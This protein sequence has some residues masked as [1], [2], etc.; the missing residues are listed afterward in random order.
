MVGITESDHI[1][2]VCQRLCF[3]VILLMC[4]DG[5]MHRLSGPV[6]LAVGIK[7]E[8]IT[9]FI[10]RIIIK[11]ATVSRLSRQVTILPCR[12]EQFRRIVSVTVHPIDSFSLFVTSQRH[13]LVILLVSLIERQLQLG[14]W[15][16]LS[17]SGIHCHITDF[18]L[19]QA[20]LQEQHIA[21]IENHPLRI[22]LVFGSSHLH[23]V[24][25]YGQRLDLHRILTG[26][27]FLLESEILGEHPFRSL[28]QFQFLCLVMGTDLAL[29]RMVQSGHLD[30]KLR[31]VT[32]GRD[33][34]FDRSVG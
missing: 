24:D 34:H 19:W 31:K 27:V 30:L 8:D 9:S 7:M 11:I 26:I 29:P 4:Q 13:H 23:Q 18:V 2:P 33:S 5:G 6:D 15:H 17:C 28:Y 14:S 16:R 10:I 22:N 25:A 1:L 32:D 20:L 21:Y 3:Q 12:H